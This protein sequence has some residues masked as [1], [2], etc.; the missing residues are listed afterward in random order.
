MH[1]PSPATRTIRL[2]PGE[3]IQQAMARQGIQSNTLTTPIQRTVP[4]ARSQYISPHT[5]TGKINIGGVQSVYVGQQNKGNY[6]QARLNPQVR[7]KTGMRSIK[8]SLGATSMYSA[9][10]KEF[11]NTPEMSQLMD[12]LQNEREKRKLA[13]GER[14]EL[15]KRLEEEKRANVE[16]FHEIE[17]LK[18]MNNQMT[19]EMK[20]VG[21]KLGGHF[22]M[23]DNE[24]RTRDELMLENVRLIFYFF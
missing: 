20:R 19:H 13:E 23:N 10:P 24:V 6:P 2:K 18:L 17:R 9:L 11:Q 15:V 22:D 3:T 5:Q 8:L 4:A 7:T 21:E 14:D 1:Q 12:K 16:K